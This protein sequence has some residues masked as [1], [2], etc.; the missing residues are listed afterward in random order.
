M[1]IN[2]A[3]EAGDA[4][5]STTNVLSEAAITSHSKLSGCFIM[6]QEES[7]ERPHVIPV[8][9]LTQP[10]AV[11]AALLRDE[12]SKVGFFYLTGHSVPTDVQQGC[13][14]AMG[15]FFALPSEVKADRFGCDGR[16]W[17]DGPRSKWGGHLPPGASK[18]DPNNQS[19]PDQ[20]ESWS[21]TR[22]LQED[23]PEVVA[24][25]ALQG[26]N[27]WPDPSQL[28]DFHPKVSAYFATV[29]ALGPRVMRLVALAYG[30]P[31]DHFSREGCFDEALVTLGA[32]HYS[33]RVS[34]PEEGVLGIGAHTDYGA[35]TFLATNEV[36]GL[37]I[38]PP[39][40]GTA[41]DELGLR[42]QG[43]VSHSWLDVPP[44]EGLF[45]VNIGDM[46]ER[47][48]NGKLPSTLHRVVNSSGKERY[49]LALFYEPNADCAI[50][51][52][53]PCR[54]QQGECKYPRVERYGD[55][56]QAKFDATGGG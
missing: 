9:D 30:L 8:I 1:M 18:L 51:V 46:L 25:P 26:P 49:S 28:P 48:T 40:H 13:F 36:P 39:G 20:K 17:D 41:A 12:V 54:D 24:W 43:S 32:N 7:E 52:L 14:E 34:K 44:Q 55:W 56:L 22:E 21:M 11:N 3:D 38:S 29:S 2:K 16:R 33:T 47:W 5:A 35:L 6:S 19:E 10:D 45:I 4:H 27:A 50:E 31:A 15:E 53:P 42:A 23:H 37:Q